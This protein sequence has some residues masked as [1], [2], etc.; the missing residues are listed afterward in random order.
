MDITQNKHMLSVAERIKKH[1][2]FRVDVY[3]DHLGNKTGGYG[4]LMLEGETEPE[5]G[6]TKEY[7][8]GV[9]QKDFNTAVNGAVKLVGNDVPPEVMGIVTEMVFQLGYNG[10]S[11]FKKTL[12]YIKEGSYYQASKEML[13][14]DWAKQT[15]ER[16]MSLSKIMANIQ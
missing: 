5:G 14:S 11:K 7:W 8:E 10:T 1:E 9:F 6:Y 2:G 12:G 3:D 4:H 15:P 16:A 13:D